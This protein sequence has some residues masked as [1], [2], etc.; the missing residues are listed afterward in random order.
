MKTNAYT[1][2]NYYQEYLDKKGIS[3]DNHFDISP[4]EMQL[5]IPHKEIIDWSNDNI[6]KAINKYYSPRPYSTDDNMRQA[7]FLMHSGYNE[8]N[9]MEKNWGLN[10]EDNE[11]LI[12]MLGDVFF[13]SINIDKTKCLVRLLRYDPGHCIPLHSDS[14]GGCRSKFGGKNA[15]RYFVAVSPWDWGHFLQLHDNMVHHWNPGYTLEIPYH[16]FHCSGNCG[17]NPKYTL[18]VTGIT[19]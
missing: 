8:N 5:D 4:L 11:K 18:T 2:Q 14:Y 12:E 17:I 6:D 9:S 7:V 19:K 13:D 10:D 15:K 1:R 3:L 16:I